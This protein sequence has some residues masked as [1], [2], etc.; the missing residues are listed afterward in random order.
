[1]MVFC[2]QH[3]YFFPG[4]AMSGLIADSRTLIDRARVEAQV[5]VMH[6]K[7]EIYYQRRPKDI[8][9]RAPED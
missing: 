3:V 2:P 7:P 1:M 6:N 4:C 5:C 9:M 8:H